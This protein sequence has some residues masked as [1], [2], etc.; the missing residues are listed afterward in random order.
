MR[1]GKGEN[2]GQGTG[3]KKHNWGVK[4]AAGFLG[5][6]QVTSSLSCQTAAP[7]RTWML[8]VTGENKNKVADVQEWCAPAETVDADW[9]ITREIGDPCGTWRRERSWAVIDPD[10]DSLQSRWKVGLCERPGAG[11]EW[12]A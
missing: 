1:R 2:E 12:Q 7:R 8:E 4:L 6:S 3:I 5:E 11:L 9:V 10:L